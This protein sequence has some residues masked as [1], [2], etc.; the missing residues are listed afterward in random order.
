[1]HSVEFTHKS[2][3]RRLFYEQVK[4]YQGELVAF[5]DDED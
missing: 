3:S 1:M 2:G 4:K 5:N